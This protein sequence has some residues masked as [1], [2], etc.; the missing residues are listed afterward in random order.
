MTDQEKQVITRSQAWDI[1][2]RLEERVKVEI[3]QTH[4]DILMRELE[5][6][7][8]IVDDDNGEDEA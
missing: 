7:Y 3:P 8:T 1:I 5:D 6:D 4:K 2:N